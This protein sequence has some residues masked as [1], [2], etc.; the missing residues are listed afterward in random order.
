MARIIA[1]TITDNVESTAHRQPTVGG[2]GHLKLEKKP[3]P[4]H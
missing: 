3:W 2:L 4:I 1:V